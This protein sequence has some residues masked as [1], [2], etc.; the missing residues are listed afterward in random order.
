[1]KRVLITGASGFIGSNLCRY[2]AEHDC[3]VYGLV[4]PT[5]DLRLLEGTPAKLVRGDL[6]DRDSPGLPDNL[7]WVIHAA[8]LVSDNGTDDECRSHIYQATA[9]LLDWLAREAPRLERFVYVSTALVLGYGK[10]GIG[11]ANPGRSADSVPYVRWKRAT[12]ALVLEHWRSRGLPAV[13]LRPSDVFGPRDRTSCEH[14]C[15]AVERGIPLRVGRG[16]RVFAFCH[17]DNFCLAAHRACMADGILGNCYTVTNAKPMSWGRFFG[18]MQARLGRRQV[19]SVPSALVFVLAYVQRLW[20]MVSPGY[21]PSMTL[22]RARRVTTDT[23]YDIGDTVRDL[24]YHPDEDE[25][26]QLSSITDWHLR[27]CACRAS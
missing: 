2:L 10:L 14:F 24:D 5:S 18:F 13:V 21:M 9:N 23:S 22:Y 16:D 1:L 20:R 4:R 26:S 12:E 19:L 15:R 11:Q 27:S 17:S 25:D 3:D 8:A 6:T 7:D